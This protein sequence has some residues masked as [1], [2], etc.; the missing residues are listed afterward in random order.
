MTMFSLGWRLDCAG[1]FHFRHDLPVAARGFASWPGAAAAGPD[2]WTVPTTTPS[3]RPRQITTCEQTLNDAWGTGRAGARANEEAESRVKAHGTRLISEL[4]TVFWTPR[5]TFRR[6][7]I[8]GEKPVAI[9]SSACGEP[10]FYVSSRGGSSAPALAADRDHRQFPRQLLLHDLDRALVVPDELRV[11]CGHQALEA[12]ELAAAPVVHGQHDAGLDLADHVDHQRHAHGVGAV[13]RHHQHVDAAELVEMVR[14]QAVM[15]MAEMGDAEVAY[16][17]DED[18]VAVYAGRA[19]A[20]VAGVGRHVPHL[21]V[22]QRDLV[23]GLGLA[24]LARPAAQDVG[25]TLLRIV[26]EMRGVGVIHGDDV[27]PPA[28]AVD[29]VVVGDGAHALRRVDLVAGMAEEG[30][31]HAVGRGVGR[32]LEAVERHH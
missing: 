15:Q 22:L 8:A 28:E 5:V 30:D 23:P 17:I 26:G 11:E 27:G 7:Q 29:S 16:G 19:A 10:I 20:P 4:W 21:H 1:L 14:G 6:P 12:V 31:G 18:R 2:P 32:Q 9:G 25:D 13:D 3:Q 24:R